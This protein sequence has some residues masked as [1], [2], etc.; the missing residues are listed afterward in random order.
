MNRIESIY[1]LIDE[2]D[3][4]IDVGCDQAKLSIMLA[5]RNQSSIACDISENVIKRAKMDIKSPLIDLRVSNGL[6]T[7]KHTF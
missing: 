6:S 7:T 4:V 1:S 3:K 2:S 5:R